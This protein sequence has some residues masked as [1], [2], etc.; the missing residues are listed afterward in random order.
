MAG[1]SRNRAAAKRVLVRR[2]DLRPVYER[3]RAL[4]LANAPH[5]PARYRLGRRASRT[6]SGVRERRGS[7][8][9]ALATSAGKPNALRERVAVYAGGRS[10]IAVGESV[11][12]PLGESVRHCFSEC[13]GL[14]GSVRL[15]QRLARFAEC[16]AVADPSAVGLRG[17]RRGAVTGGARSRAGA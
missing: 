8:A 1:R 12:Q 3:S 4:S 9:D 10:G 17:A 6:L 2:V 5:S 14:S 13:L 15:G 11:G 16:L 7:D